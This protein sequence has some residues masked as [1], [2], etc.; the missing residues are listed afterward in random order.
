MQSKGCSTRAAEGRT[1]PA[2]L[3]PLDL[4]RLL[5]LRGAAGDKVA[6]AYWPGQVGGKSTVPQIALQL[7]QLYPDPYK[8]QNSLC[9]NMFYN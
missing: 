7:H 6:A 5:Q 2:P 9:Q 1:P 8:S 3:V 4:L